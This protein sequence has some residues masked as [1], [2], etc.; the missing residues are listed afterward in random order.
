MFA[1]MQLLEIKGSFMEYVTL[2]LSRICLPRTNFIWIIFECI[3]T[4]VVTAVSYL[5][6]LF[7]L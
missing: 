6:R 1:E 3:S 5:A 2:E 7:N 4:S